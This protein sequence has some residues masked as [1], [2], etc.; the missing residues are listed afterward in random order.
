[1]NQKILSALA[2]G[3]LAAGMGPAQAMDTLPDLLTD[4]RCSSI[5]A[6]Q[7]RYGKESKNC[8][9]ATPKVLQVKLSAQQAEHVFAVADTQAIKQFKVLNVLKYNGT[10]TPEIWRL[11][12]GDTLDVS[13]QNDLGA[14]EQPMQALNLHTH[15]LIVSPRLSTKEMNG[16]HEIVGTVGDS[17][18]VC[19]VPNGSPLSLCNGLPV[20]KQSNQLHYNIVIPK[21][22]PPGLFWYHPHIHGS[23]AYHIGTGLS[24]LI[25]VEDQLSKYTKHSGGERF[26]MLKDFQLI[27]N[28][29]GYW[30]VYT[31]NNLNSVVHPGLN[32][33]SCATPLDV[34]A[35]QGFCEGP[36]NNGKI[37]VGD[38][39]WL[40]TLNGV[41]RPNIEMTNPHGE[42]WHLANTSANM[43]YR[44]SMKD[45]KGNAVPLQLVARDGIYVD[46][47]KSLPKTAPIVMMPASRI[48]IFVSPQI[49]KIGLQKI[50]ATLVTEGVNTGAVGPDA[51]GLAPG[52]V[53]P[54]AVL[55]T[56]D[57]VTTKKAAPPL[58]VSQTPKTRIAQASREIQGK[59]D[60]QLA[61]LMKPI[62]HGAHGMHMAAP[63]A[64]VVC[65]EA[66]LKKLIN[67]DRLIVLNV[68]AGA[69]GGDE[70]VMGADR[71]KSNSADKDIQR[72]V[73]ALANNS[74]KTI[75]VGL[76]PQV[77]TRAGRYETWIIANPMKDQINK[78]S[79]DS[80]NNSIN[81]EL[82]NFHLHQV[83]F[84]VLEVKD[85]LT[86]NPAPICDETI[87][88]NVCKISTNIESG[89]VDTY[90][91]PAGGWIKIQ[92]GFDETQVGDFVYHCHILEHE[93]GGMMAKISVYPVK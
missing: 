45:D 61:Q 65:N 20:D 30:D 51:N 48:S 53:W 24:G 4:N 50:A 59:K 21:K 85:N 36:I 41:V 64:P 76:K 38:G 77:C 39:A 73:Y 75:P 32:Y 28:G 54:A 68:R 66:D 70:F 33:P 11:H 87:E 18:L 55:A 16:T 90:P 57:I 56:V 42:I 35:N 63:I 89:L 15:G 80:L 69:G 9:S 13:M 81:N 23:A 78:A 49:S 71:I 12:V 22:H 14:V 52:D 46:S 26:I 82:H 92:V 60:E 40:F 74:Q 25:W 29:D 93:D 1:M 3:T 17:V 86:P 88:K 72:A 62:A 34:K 2:V 84:K 43:T 27:K 91:V 19:S 7:N 58:T 37:K 47:N 5:P 6:E 8:N 10:L 83:K 44:I 31:K 67:E 79:S